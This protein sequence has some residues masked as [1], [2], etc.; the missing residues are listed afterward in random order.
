MKKVEK[1]NTSLSELEPITSSE[2]LTF[3]SGGVSDADGI[4][5]VN[6]RQCLWCKD[7]INGGQ[8]LDE[9]WPD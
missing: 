3:V 5:R 2:I 8:K 9:C 6:A 4:A 1:I 7:R